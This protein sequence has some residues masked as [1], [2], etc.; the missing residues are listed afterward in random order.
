MARRGRA[1]GLHEWHKENFSVWRLLIRNS[2]F[3]KDLASVATLRGKLFHSIPKNWATERQEQ[4]VKKRERRIYK[5]KAQVCKKWGLSNLPIIFS[6]LWEDFIEFTVED[7][8]A[9]YNKETAWERDQYERIL[10]GFWPILPYPV[11]IDCGEMP[12]IPLGPAR[13]KKLRLPRAIL[14]PENK[15]YLKIWIDSSKPIEFLLPLIERELRGTSWHKKFG[16]TKLGR[17]ES[18]EFQ[19]KVFDLVNGNLQKEG[20]KNFKNLA[21]YLRKSSSTVRSAYWTACRKIGVSGARGTQPISDPGPFDTCLDKVCR[22]AKN[23]ASLD[24][25]KDM[26]CPSHRKL[27]EKYCMK[28]LREFLHPDPSTIKT[29]SRGRRSLKQSAD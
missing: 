18:L 19:L 24:R 1:V 25:V 8:D 26:L 10:G 3:Q 22:A 7:L 9:L 21:R 13:K 23:E 6:D 28:S 20:Y 5:K 15:N 14:G 4:T 2:A 29:A 12:P 16:K 27:W 11:K 17:S